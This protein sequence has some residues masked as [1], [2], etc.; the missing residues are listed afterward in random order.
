MPNILCIDTSTDICSVVLGNENGLLFERESRE[1]R[2]HSSKAGVFVDEILKEAKAIG[3]E[4]PDAIA[5]CAGP[6]SYTGLRIGMSLAKGLCYGYDVPLVAVDSLQVMAREVADTVELEKEAVLCP[7]I[8]ARRM[9]VY[10]SLWSRSMKLQGE[11]EAKIIDEASYEAFADKPFYYFG[12]GAEKCQEML[13]GDHFKLIPGIMPMAHTLLVPALDRFAVENFEDLAYSEPFYL[14][15][16]QTTVSK[17]N[18]LG[19]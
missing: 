15:Q 2:D 9:E 5:V 7:M 6:G 13:L 12:T 8:D 19:L 11:A 10:T 17:K 16:F 3:L 18:L 14:K 1:G 4:K